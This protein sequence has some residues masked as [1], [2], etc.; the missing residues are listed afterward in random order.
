MALEK[1]DGIAGAYVNSGIT[2]H[3][4]KAGE[5]DRETIAKT[6]AP[7]KMTIQEVEQ[8]EGKPF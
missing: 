1:I 4:V 2:I 5:L 8:L 3:L 7:F 6:L